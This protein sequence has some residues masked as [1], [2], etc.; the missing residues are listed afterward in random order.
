[1]S[2]VDL[3]KNL[4]DL[5]TASFLVA[6]R[7][8]SWICFAQS[9][10]EESQRPKCLCWCTLV[11]GDSFRTRGGDILLQTLDFVNIISLVFHPTSSLFSV[12]SKECTVKLF[13]DQPLWPEI[14]AMQ[15][16]FGYQT[17]NRRKNTSPTSSQARQSKNFV[18]VKSRPIRHWQV[19]RLRAGNFLSTPH[20]LGLARPGIFP[21]HLLSSQA[22][23]PLSRSH[24]FVCIWTS[25]EVL[26]GLE[27]VNVSL[28]KKN[29]VE[30]LKWA[31]TPPLQQKKMSVLK[32]WGNL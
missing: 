15:L 22:R 18:T 11:I 6:F 5:S 4:Q 29:F 9:R 14:S 21:S 19:P 12:N 26:P 10:D 20:C 30:A 3:S 16:L 2:R 23:E 27:L 8:V 17:V 32:A 31:G 7:Q 1:M 24:H 25:L 28:L 13:F